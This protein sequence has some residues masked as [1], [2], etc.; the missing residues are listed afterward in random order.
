MG[1]F[2]GSAFLYSAT[3]RTMQTFVEEPNQKQ[4]KNHIVIRA[5]AC[6]VLGVSIFSFYILA[7]TPSVDPV[8]GLHHHIVE[9]ANLCTSA[10]VVFGVVG[11]AERF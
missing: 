7:A 6:I 1:F 4:F 9:A 5:L 8:S 10:V 11:L 3:Y 2:V